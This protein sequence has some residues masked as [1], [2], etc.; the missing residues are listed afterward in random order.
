MVEIIIVD[1]SDDNKT[2]DLVKRLN[3]KVSYINY[4][5]DSSLNLDQ[6]YDHAVIN[7]RGLYCWPIPDDDILIKNSISL[8]F[9]NIKK[10]FDL[11]L[12]NLKCYNVD[13]TIDLSQKLK[14]SNQDKVYTN[15]DLNEFFYEMGSL[16]S[17]I[18]SIIIKKN[19]WTSINRNPY[20]GTWFI[21]VGV[22]LGSDKIKKIKFLSKPIIKYRS[23]NSSWTSKSF[24]IW[25]IKWPKLINSFSNLNQKVKNKI[26]PINSWSSF[27]KLL[28]SRA[29]G[30]YN[31]KI[32]RKYIKKD[33]GSKKFNYLYLL[34]S[35]IPILPL[36]FSLIFYC[37]LFKRKARF[38][39]YNIIMSS[40]NKKLGF[41]ISRILFMKLN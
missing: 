39:L 5:K 21:H 3:Q 13:M 37:S 7:S 12:V 33:P 2:F 26:A 6:G 8:V 11:I 24:E 38:S 1:S 14:E 35:L 34:I 36:N 17:Y 19:I 29:M 25:Y 40:R 28:K 41:M 9:K 10:N 15:K 22:I 20:F 31:Y 23:G 16:C 32:Y 27:N 18:G 30:E 4:I